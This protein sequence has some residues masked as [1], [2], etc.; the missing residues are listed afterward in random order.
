MGNLEDDDRTLAHGDSLSL[1]WLIGLLFTGMMSAVVLLGG[2]VWGNVTSQMN[3]IS[4]QIKEM[5]SDIR[6]TL[7]DMN[8][9]IRVTQAEANNMKL[10]IQDIKSRFKTLMDVLNNDP[11]SS[12]RGT[13]SGEENS[14]RRR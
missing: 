3:S 13:G 12:R 5:N 9:D 4:L 8:G 7:R 14:I 11:Q 6:V 2:L 1:R 10:E